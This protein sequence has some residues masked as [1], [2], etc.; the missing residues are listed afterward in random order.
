MLIGVL[1][2]SSFRY[3]CNRMKQ[4]VFNGLIGILLLLNACGSHTAS[5]T[6]NST[7][8]Q[9]E[10]KVAKPILFDQDSLNYCLQQPGVHPS[11]KK[12]LQ[13]KGFLP[14]AGFDIPEFVALTDSVEKARDLPRKFYMVV[15][16]RTL[17]K[18][19][20]AYSEMLSDFAHN[21]IT[22]HSVQF[23]SLFVHNSV[24]KEKD[25]QRWSDMVMMELT[26]DDVGS[27]QKKIAAYEK[28]IIDHCRGANSEV[29]DKCDEFCAYLEGGG[30]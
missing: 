12:L 11:Y 24:L 3:F 8:Q 23:F 16:T 28:I 1:F 15:L 22:A 26:L 30:V 18:A 14:E 7:Y 10:I 25:L 2:I 6:A 4:V 5:E 21:Y 20:G 13:V 27:I 17:D 9:Q 19:D 29:V